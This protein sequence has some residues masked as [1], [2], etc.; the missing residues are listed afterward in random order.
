MDALPTHVTGHVQTGAMPVNICLNG[1]KERGAVLISH[2]RKCSDTRRCCQ[3]KI[4]QGEGRAAAAVEHLRGHVAFA[5]CVLRYRQSFVKRLFLRG[6]PRLT[7]MVC[8]G[9]KT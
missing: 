6:H 4:V 5:R 8:L 3:R 1:I 7:E 9:E 2:G